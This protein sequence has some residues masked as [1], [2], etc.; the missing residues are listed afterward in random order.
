[1]LLTTLQGFPYRTF[2]DTNSTEQSARRP[3]SSAPAGAIM[4]FTTPYR[5]ATL[6]S[7]Q[8]GRIQKLAVE[9]GQAVNVGDLLISLDTGVQK[10]RTEAAR[11]E[12]DSTTK[13]ELARVQMEYDRDELE[14]I[15][16]LSEMTAASARELRDIQAK[17]DTSRLNYELTKLEH[18]QAVHNYKI[19]CELLAQLELR[20]PFA[21]Y[22]TV[23]HKEV[24]ETVDELEGVIELADVEKL[25]VT[26]DCPLSLAG[27]IRLGDEASITPIDDNWPSRRGIIR[28]INPVADAGSQTF[29]IKLVVTNADGQWPA[30]LMVAVDFSSTPSARRNPVASSDT[31]MTATTQPSE[32][33]PRQP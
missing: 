3:T 7:L 31:A 15:K 32:Q 27:R 33:R 11:L 26:A 23:R 10:A 18:E 24:G 25:L 9:E 2:A 5:K 19:Q 14:R 13:I 29:K 1:M 6:A 22:V 16:R 17:A 12:A 21:G 8:K 30:G 28:Y 20:A 4:G